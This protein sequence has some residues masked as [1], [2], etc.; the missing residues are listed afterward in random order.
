M[1]FA[2]PQYPVLTGSLGSGTSA[3]SATPWSSTIGHA[4]PLVGGSPR[5]PTTRA[6]S[7]NKGVEI[8]AIDVQWQRHRLEKLLLKLPR[9][10]VF[11]PAHRRV[12][13]QPCI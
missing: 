2:Y 6:K 5:C 11:D 3:P 12:L 10:G 8:V 7:A 13:L 4:L 1:S 9:L